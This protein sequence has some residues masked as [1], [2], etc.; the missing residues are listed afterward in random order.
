MDFPEFRLPNKLII[1]HKETEANLI[2][3]VKMCWSFFAA[4]L[5]GSYGRL[6]MDRFMM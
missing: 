4:T 1:G 2:M 3:R 5:L 6:F